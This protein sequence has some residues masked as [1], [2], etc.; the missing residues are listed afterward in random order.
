MSEVD[1]TNLKNE[2]I[3]QESLTINVDKKTLDLIRERMEEKYNNFWGDVIDDE[4]KKTIEIAEQLTPGQPYKIN[5][6]DYIYKSIGMKSWRDFARIKS[7]ADTE[8]DPSKAADLILE[9]Q[10]GMLTKCFGMT[11]DEAGDIPPGEARMVIDAAAYKVIHP[12][13]LHPER[14]R[15]GSMLENK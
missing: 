13:P 5:G 6:K 4:Q 2:E 3:K 8:K 10:I 12:V 7:R 1:E 14:L 9:Y 15:N 11:E